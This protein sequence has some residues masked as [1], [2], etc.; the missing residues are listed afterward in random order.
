[1][2]E[3][4]LNMDD[5]NVK[6]AYDFIKKHKNTFR[7][8]VSRAFEYRDQGVKEISIRDICAEI[9]WKNHVKISNSITPALARI[10]EK[11]YPELHFK[12]KPS[13]CEKNKAHAFQ[14]ESG[15]MCFMF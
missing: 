9:R 6:K 1:M 13:K 14:I 4:E 15:Q 11:K 10:I 5:K 2:Q 8:I 3:K 7:D 12:K